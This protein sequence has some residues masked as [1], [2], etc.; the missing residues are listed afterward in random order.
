MK[1]IKSTE[2]TCLISSNDDGILQ[3]LNRNGVIF[4]LLLLVVFMILEI[5]RPY[6]TLREIQVAGMADNL[7]KL[8][9]TL[10]R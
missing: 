3:I 7:I 4:G 6:Q 2:S 1:F 8:E 9:I 5:K 10:G